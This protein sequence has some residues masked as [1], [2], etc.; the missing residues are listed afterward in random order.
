MP[1]SLLGWRGRRWS[2]FPCSPRNSPG[3][4]PA[5]RRIGANYFLWTT[6][7]AAHKNH[8]NALK[9]LQIYYERLDGQLNC[10]VT[11]V[12]ADRL[13]TEPHPH[14]QS[15]PGIIAKS[16]KL[17][18]RLRLLGELPDASYRTRLAG[19]RFLWHAASIDNGTFSV[20]EA[21]YLGVPA[22][23]S[24]YPAMQEINSQYLLGL[25]WM[26]AHDPD[27]MATQLKHMESEAAACRAT[28]PS[29]EHLMS[30]RMENLA[31]HYWKAVEDDL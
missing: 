16:P 13:L 29:H 12:G 25:S 23:S 18:N 1:C 11:G 14:L 10:H 5:G 30:Q 4:K 15:L 27:D 28:L 20:I 31:G 8:E 6:N 21:A 19:A 9:A 26:D 24:I 17:K 22:L 3:R 7:L 2:A